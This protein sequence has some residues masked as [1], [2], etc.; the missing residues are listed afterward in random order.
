MGARLSRLA[1]TEVR[2]LLIT[3][4]RVSLSA[5]RASQ[6]ALTSD[7]VIFLCAAF[8][9]VTIL[10]PVSPEANI[11]WW[12]KLAGFAIFFTIVPLLY[13]LQLLA[14]AT[15]SVRMSGFHLFE[16]VLLLTAA[17]LVEIFDHSVSPLLFGEEWR[18]WLGTASFGEQVTVNF[19][20]MLSLDLL[21]SYFVMPRIDRHAAPTV[22]DRAEAEGPDDPS[23]SPA[24]ALS[25]PPGLTGGLVPSQPAASGLTGS[26][27][28]GPDMVEIDGQQ[29]AIASILA[30]EAEKH[31]VRVWTGDQEIYGRHPFG[32]LVAQMSEND[33]FSPRRGIWFSFRNIDAIRKDENGKFVIVP[34][35]GPTTVVPKAKAREVKQL[36][37]VR[38]VPSQ[39]PST[40]CD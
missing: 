28:L 34:F 19:I 40:A 6:I 12:M 1:G 3:G 31:Y 14:L 36:L 11:S 8:V 5:R 20:M 25:D 37:A 39:G 30:V 15:V 21:F 29:T 16:P 33:G 26:D 13:F 22:D 7:S 10:Y 35:F 32:K 24:I 27:S 4:Q 38:P 23:A 2:L 9:L 17:F 18:R